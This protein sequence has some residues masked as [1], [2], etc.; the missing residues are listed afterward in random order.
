MLTRVA[1]Q[2]SWKE[3]FGSFDE[4]TAAFSPESLKSG[5]KVRLAKAWSGD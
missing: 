1:P 4:A 2:G 5:L 3:N